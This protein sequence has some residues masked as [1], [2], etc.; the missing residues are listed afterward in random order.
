MH[1]GAPQGT[2]PSCTYIIDYNSHARN[3]TQPNA[4]R[5]VGITGPHGKLMKISR[6][7][8]RAAAMSNHYHLE[9]L[10]DDASQL[11]LTDD[12]N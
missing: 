3:S 4:S 1:R 2:K 8:R 6:V 9:D 10:S 5:G 7:A 12:A 11:R